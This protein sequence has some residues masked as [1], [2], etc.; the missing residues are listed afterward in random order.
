MRDASQ[1]FWL[2]KL[3]CCVAGK[4]KFEGGHQNPGDH[5]RRQTAAAWGSAPIPQQPL[6][7]RGYGAGGYGQDEFYSDSYEQW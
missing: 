1:K 2:L 4:R 5:K 3:L 6:H 7:A